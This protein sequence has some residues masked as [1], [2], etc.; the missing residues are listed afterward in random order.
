ML[1]MSAIKKGTPHMGSVNE[2][3][4]RISDPSLTY[5]ER[6]QLRCQ[7]AKQLEDIGNYEAAREALGELWPRVGERPMLEELNLEIAAEVLMRAGAL[8][9]WIGSVRQ[10]EGSQGLAKD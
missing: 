8:A 10:I 4:H 7:L 6:A 3:F 5:N 2:L 9:G 1:L